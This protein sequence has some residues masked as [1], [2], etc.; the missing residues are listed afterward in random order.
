MPDN[1]L[2]KLP[3][4]PLV[5]ALFEFKWGRPD[6]PESLGYP[7]V[8]GS[9]YG[10]LKDRFPEIIDLP[11]NMVPSSITTHLVR[12]QFRRAKD[13]WPIIQVGPG[14]MTV[15]ENEGYTGWPAFFDVIGNALRHL[16][17]A[18]P[19]P[20]AIQPQSF[21]LRYINAIDFDSERGDALN[22]LAEHLKTGIRLDETV[23]SVGDPRR[24][25]SSLILRLSF[26]LKEPQGTVIVQFSSGAKSG[27][28]AIIWEL[29]VESSPPGIRDLRADADTWLKSA[30]AVI[31]HWFVALSRG[32]LLE[33][34]RRQPQ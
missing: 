3:N 26:A 1:V 19:K 2:E 15:N 31:E 6:V 4:Q 7:I 30:H 17:D 23:F 34:F 12:H 14:I 24:N 9:L 21:L 22:F 32:T 27:K 28:P 8:V 33:N 16:C 10:K 18:H 25:P 5:E 29:M 20:E 11:A 13:Q